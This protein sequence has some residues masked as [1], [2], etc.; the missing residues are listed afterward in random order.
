MP[1]GVAREVSAII[2][3]G[4]SGRECTRGEVRVADDEIVRAKARQYTKRCVTNAGLVVD[5]MMATPFSMR[6]RSA[7]C[8]GDLEYLVAIAVTTGF[9]PDL[10]RAGS[11]R[12]SGVAA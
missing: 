2:G 5:G 10:T 4:A 7:T 9:P 11:D 1:E 6:N 3:V 12:A 8:A